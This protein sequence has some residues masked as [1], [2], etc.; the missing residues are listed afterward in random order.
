MLA[1][2]LSQDPDVSNR[3]IQQALFFLA[4]GSRKHALD[5]KLVELPN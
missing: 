3:L 5:R 1:N 4:D 2:Q